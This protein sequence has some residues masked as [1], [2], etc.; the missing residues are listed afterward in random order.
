MISRLSL[1]LPLE[2]FA[3]RRKRTNKEETTRKEE[4]QTIKT[5]REEGRGRGDVGHSL[6][7]S[8]RKEKKRKTSKQSD[9]KGKLKIIIQCISFLG[10]ENVSSFCSP[11]IQ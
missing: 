9:N 1:S 3:E 8:H 10:E 6:F 7:R 4:I 5:G 11:V 2:D